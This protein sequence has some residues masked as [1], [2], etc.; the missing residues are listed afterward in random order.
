MRVP[1]LGKRGQ[2]KTLSEALAHTA[3]PDAADFAQSHDGEH[4]GFTALNA[5]HPPRTQDA[6]RTVGADVVFLQEALGALTYSRKIDNSPRPHM[7]SR[8]HDGP[9][10]ATVVTP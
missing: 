8:S 3:V 6:V 5:V 9:Q 2:L 10:F 1:T 7:N 4:P